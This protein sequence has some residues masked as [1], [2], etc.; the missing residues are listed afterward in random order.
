ME[1]FGIGQRRVAQ[2][3]EALH[4]VDGKFVE[5][6]GGVQLAC[7]RGGRAVVAAEAHAIVGLAADVILGVVAAVALADDG[8][9]GVD[10]EAVYYHGADAGRGILDVRGGRCERWVGEEGAARIFQTLLPLGLIQLQLDQRLHRD[11]RRR[12]GEIL[13]RRL[14]LKALQL[15][16]LGGVS[17]QGVLVGFVGRGP[18]RVAQGGGI[19]V[20][21]RE[22]NGTVAAAGAGIGGVV[23]DADGHADD[24]LVVALLAGDGSV[25][26]QRF[27]GLVIVDAV[28]HEVGPLHVF[29][30]EQVLLAAEFLLHRVEQ[31]VG[32][33]GG[34]GWATWLG[35]ED[36]QREGECGEQNDGCLHFALPAWPS[37][38]GG[39]TMGGR[40]VPCAWRWVS[41]L[42]T[43]MAGATA[44]TGIL[45]LSAPQMP[46]K[47]S[48]LSPV[49]RMLFSAACG[50]PT[51]ETPRTSSS[52]LP[53]T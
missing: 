19:V 52:G 53:S 10:E 35:G 28:L 49:A 36:W 37:S 18:E 46:L 29:E 24:A 38:V 16:L 45:P 13:F 21:G 17:A 1:V 5:R 26:G 9:F 6:S 11:G 42:E 33:G 51:I 48:C 2:R 41:M 32:H 44:L 27:V 15:R 12:R 31:R 47:M 14:F 30:D 22:S 20:L 3:L 40:A 25:V 23:A 43:S 50:V 39:G 8:A 4:V 7:D 34:L